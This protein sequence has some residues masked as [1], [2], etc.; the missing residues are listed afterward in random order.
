MRI[1]LIGGECT[2]KSTLA[3]DLADSLPGEVIVIPD[4]LR[5]FVREQGRSPHLG[6][7]AQIMALQAEQ[8]RQASQ[9]NPAWIIADPAPAMTAIYSQIYFDDESLLLKAQEQ[10]CTYD[11]VLWCD[12]DLPWEPDPGQRD[13]A[14]MRAVAHH[15][16]ATHLATASTQL[17]SG[18]ASERLQSVLTTLLR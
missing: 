7:Q 2:G 13:G 1:G 11:V 9:G 3:R 17:I 15:A 12:M 4:V 14:H 6:E 5:T 10:L 8:E 18:T 16:I